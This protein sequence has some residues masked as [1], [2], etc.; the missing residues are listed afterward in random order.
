MSNEQQALQCYAKC[1][2]ALAGS[3]DDWHAM[4]WQLITLA[5]KAAEGA[6]S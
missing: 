2:L 3:N 6:R 4:E 1:D 5:L